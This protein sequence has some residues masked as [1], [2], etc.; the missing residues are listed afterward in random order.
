MKQKATIYSIAQE[1]GVSVATVSRVFNG[2]D[3]EK[4]GSSVRQRVESL[5]AKYGY[6]PS[7]HAKGLSCGKSSLLGI[8]IL[9]LSDPL[10]NVGMIEALEVAAAGKKYNVI[11]GISNWNT[12]REA[13]SI[14]VMLEK[15]VDGI[16][17]QP[18]GKPDNVLLRKI[19][20][21]NLPIIWLNKDCGKKI[22]GAYN[23]EFASG[24]MA[25]EYLKKHC[26]KNPVFVAQKRDQHTTLRLKG[27]C[28]AARL[29]GIIS[30]YQIL[31]KNLR[32]HGQLRG[33]F[34]VMLE[35]INNNDHNIDGAFFACRNL[36]QGAY[37]A[38][39]KLGISCR[40]FPLIGHNLFAGSDDYYP[41]PSICPQS[42]EIGLEAFNIFE[43]LLA[44]KAAHSVYLQP[45]LKS[46]EELFEDD[47]E[48]S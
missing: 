36:A 22:P 12:K 7:I 17:W 8:Q 42:N 13:E 6:N 45:L 28:E 37:A 21:E 32:C 27:W 43:Q 11:L 34:D 47:K 9:S 29:S 33:G 14:N 15:G 1:A 48:K 16:I 31:L 30:P 18:I 46:N 41:I 44:N 35:I 25:W 40:E 2:K 3:P 26:C 38:L 24:K 19:I 20:S 10:S 23:D 39:Q 4:V 5:I